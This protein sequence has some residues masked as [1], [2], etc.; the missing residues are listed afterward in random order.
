MLHFLLQHAEKTHLHSRQPRHS[1]AEGVPL[2]G[3]QAKV[4]VDFLQP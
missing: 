2:L 1:Y 3:T 4:A